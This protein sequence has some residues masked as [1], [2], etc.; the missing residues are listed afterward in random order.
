LIRAGKWAGK[1]MA[2][3]NLRP[4][5]GT[6]AGAAPARAR[7]PVVERRLPELLDA[8]EAPSPAKRSDAMRLATE[9]DR[10]E[11]ELSTARAQMAELEARAEI[12]PLTDVLN[13]RGFEREL[14][15]SLAHAKRY[16]TSAAL[17]YLDLDGFKAVN[18]RNGHA[19]GDAVL[20]AVASVLARHVRASDVVARLGGDEFAVLLWHLTE[21][22]A[23]GKAQM[24]EAA[25]ARTT[26]I[27]AGAPLSVGA[28]AGAALLLPLDQPADV[29]ERADRA[30][31]ARKANRRQGAESSFE[32][33]TSG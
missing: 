14:K 29:I 25:I 15:R 20:K 30:M 1:D 5:R 8:P 31:Y 32:R 27:H 33:P 7:E 23:Q 26:A 28:S 21:A 12:D 22:D 10:L 3:G 4:D 9:V 24:L 17:I 13:R 11:R 16:G 2:K 18:D 19:A 6:K